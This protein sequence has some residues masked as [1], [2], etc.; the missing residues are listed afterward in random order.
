MAKKGPKPISFKSISLNLIDAYLEHAKTLALK[1]ELRSRG[2]VITT[3]A[4]SVENHVAKLKVNIVKARANTTRADRIKANRTKAK[5]AKAVAVATAKAEA[6]FAARNMDAA[7]NPVILKEIALL[8]ATGR[9]KQALQYME[10]LCPDVIQADV[11]LKVGELY[12][13]NSGKRPADD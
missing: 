4:K 1:A 6:K 10:S 5:I 7:N 8:V 2:F 12:R 13:Q 11:M 3:K 9:T